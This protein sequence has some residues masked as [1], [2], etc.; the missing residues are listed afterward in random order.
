MPAIR[1]ASCVAIVVL[2][3]P[4]ALSSQRAPDLLDQLTVTSQLP[5]GC[6][7]AVDRHSVG[8]SQPAGI[9]SNPWRGSDREVIASIREMMYGPARVPDG[10]PLDAD[11]LSRFLLRLSEG[12]GAG[13]IALYSQ[14]R[15]EDVAVYALTFS[16]STRA[17][18]HR[19]A[20]RTNPRPAVWFEKGNTVVAVYGDEG[21]CSRAIRSHIEFLTR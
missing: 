10:P 14:Q 12:I 2:T 4:I 15:S 13:Y 3:L 18:N 6:S 21:P 9:D 11:A 17:V 16:S 1:S 8:L 7:L 19:N 20:A 5:E